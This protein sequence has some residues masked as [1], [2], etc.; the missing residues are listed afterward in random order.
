MHLAILK[1][2][3]EKHVSMIEHFDFV[4][5]LPTKDETSQ[6]DCPK[7]LLSVFY[8]HNSLQL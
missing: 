4:T 8:I 1:P 7:F 6:D 3:T 2:G 5:V